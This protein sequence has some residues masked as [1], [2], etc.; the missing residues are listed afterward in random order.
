[1]KKIRKVDHIPVMLD[2]VMTLLSPLPNDNVIDGTIGYA[3][4][5]FR[6]L[7]SIAPYGQLLGIDWDE[8]AIQYVKKKFSRDS[9]IRGRYSLVHGSYADIQAIITRLRFP[10]VHRILLDLGLSSVQLDDPLRGFG[11]KTDGNL[12]MRYD[13]SDRSQ[14]TLRA[15]DIVNRWP[16]AELQRIFADYGEERLAKGIAKHLV[17]IRKQHTIDTPAMLVRAVSEVYE[18]V[19]FKYVLLARGR[20]PAQRI[21]QALRIAV[22]DELE[23]LKRFLTDAVDIL[24]PKGRLAIISFHSLEDAIVKDFFRKESRSCN[25][26]REIPVCRC[27]HSAKFRLVTKKPLTPS[28]DEVIQNPRARSAKLR[29]VE[30]I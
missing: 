7:T 27:Q 13:A 22:N 15:W 24:A 3:G 29:V 14:V 21:F 23:N 12:D 30:K 19:P 5:A 16:E 25:C 2:E 26:P 6:L 17:E 18:N 8:N 1:M 28:T 20:H 10:R 4:H 11:M 9:D